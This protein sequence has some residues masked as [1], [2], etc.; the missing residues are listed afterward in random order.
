MFQLYSVSPHPIRIPLIILRL[1]FPD[2]RKRRQGPQ[3]GWYKFLQ[4]VDLCSNT[5]GFLSLLT[6]IFYHRFG[7]TVFATLCIIYSVSST[8]F[9]IRRHSLGVKKFGRASLS[10]TEQFCVIQCMLRI[11]KTKIIFTSEGFKPLQEPSFGRML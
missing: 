5:V 8:I 4:L 9:E 11:P 2:D 6:S 7:G 3:T 1:A 10:S